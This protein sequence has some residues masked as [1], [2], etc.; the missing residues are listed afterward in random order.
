MHLK[1]GQCNLEGPAHRKSLV[2]AT[3]LHSAKKKKQSKCVKI[4][5]QMSF[6]LLVYECDDYETSS[7]ERGGSRLLYIYMEECMQA[8]VCMCLH[9]GGTKGIGGHVWGT[10]YGKRYMC[11]FIEGEVKAEGRSCSRLQGLIYAANKRKEVR[12]RYCP[13][14]TT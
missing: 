9:G 13:C 14:A 2:P 7:C 6:P 1:R 4:T 3:T 10:C 12:S 8:H 5:A 11:G